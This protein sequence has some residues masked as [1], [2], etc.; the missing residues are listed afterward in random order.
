MNIRDEWI[1]LDT[2]IWIFGLRNHPDHSACRQI[3]ENLHSLT[4]KV[5]RQILL[6]LRANLKRDEFSTLFQLTN[7]YPNRIDIL[8]NKVAPSLVEKYQELGCRLGDAVVAA[9]VTHR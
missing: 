2:N 9:G 4:V 1:I 5:P 7:R 3:L 8:W 6:E